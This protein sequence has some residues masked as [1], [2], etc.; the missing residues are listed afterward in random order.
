MSLGIL[1]SPRKAL[2]S[3][4]NGMGAI[5]S[6]IPADCWNKPGFKDAHAAAYKKAQGQCSPSYYPYPSQEDCIVTFAD[7][8]A[9]P[10]CTGTTTSSSGFAWKNTVENPAVKA[11]QLE[12]NKV[13]TKNGYASIGTDGKLGPGT[14]GGARVADKHGGNFVSKHGLANICQSYT[15]P[16]KLL[17]AP[18]A[19]SP[20]SL[21]PLEPASSS[22][23]GGMSTKNILFI[24]LAAAAAAYLFA[25]QDKKPQRA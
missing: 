7:A 25:T 10:A 12:I 22:T 13:L 14:C 8:Y 15:E 17:T 24:G 23:F 9:K 18:S 16:A 21:E 1:D 19:S 20:S 5:A 6:T 4:L 11:M 3:K 2:A